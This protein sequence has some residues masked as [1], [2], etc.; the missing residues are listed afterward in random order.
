MPADF[1]RCVKQGGKIRTRSLKGNRFMPV[2]FIGGK[3]FAG[4]V[5]KR[6]KNGN[7]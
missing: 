4:E 6:K 7:N 5:R 3:S 2:C 1:L